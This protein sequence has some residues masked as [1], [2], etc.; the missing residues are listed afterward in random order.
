MKKVVALSMVFCFV[1]AFS[2][3]AKNV[4]DMADSEQYGEKAGG[5]LGRG[6]LNAATCFVDMPVGAVN[7][8]KKTK[9]EFVGGVGGFATGAVC[10]IFRAASGVLD[11]A[12][13]WVPSFHGI[14]ICRTYGD[15]FT[16]SAEAAAPAY[17]PAQPQTVV[18]QEPASQPAPVKKNRM[19]YIK[20]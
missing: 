13:F 17:Q 19:K 1:F 5:M 15:C 16:C 6:L 12:T 20:K 7:G 2:A 18:Y 3:Q 8:A 9:P 11:V 14:P 4:W 10:T